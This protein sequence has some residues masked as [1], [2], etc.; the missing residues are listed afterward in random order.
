MSEELDN[1][2]ENLYSPKSKHFI[3]VDIGK[4]HYGKYD[5]Y[6]RYDRYYDRYYGKYYSQADEF[7]LI[8]KES[9]FADIT[10]EEFNGY[11]IKLIHQNA[12]GKSA[13]TI[14]RIN[15]KQD[16]INH[17]PPQYDIWNA[18]SG[19]VNVKN[20]DICLNVTEIPSKTFGP[21]KGMQ[22]N[23]N[24]ITIWTDESLTI[25]KMA[26][27]HLDNLKNIAIGFHSSH[28]SLSNLNPMDRL[29]IKKIENK[30]F[31][32]EK[33]SNEKLKFHF[34]NC[35][36]DDES[37]EPGSFDGI[38]RPVEIQFYNI[39]MKIL[40]ESTFKSL[41]NNKNNTFTIFKQPRSHDNSENSFID[42]FDCRNEWL[43][44]D[45][46]FIQGLRCSSDEQSSFFSIE[47]QSY[48]KSECNLIFASKTKSEINY[49][50][51]EYHLENVRFI[52]SKY[53]T[54]N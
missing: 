46:I 32:L 44:R 52:L 35:E 4:R 39:K 41:F 54:I 18:L 30:A 9:S 34:V 17:L 14:K 38:Q 13:Q 20:I 1:L 23:L 47:I 15:I 28:C 21:L 40:P 33:Q 31:A 22:S 11:N 7:E 43:I 48:F 42:C 3:T 25:R 29:K 49:Y 24:D 51:C 19:L 16:Y 26:F 8:L 5:R 27:Y 36:F 37:F 2:D 10:F 45:D 12:F 6:D 53:L 50:P